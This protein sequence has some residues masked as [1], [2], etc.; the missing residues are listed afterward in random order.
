MTLDTALK[1][2]TSFGYHFTGKQHRN[3]IGFTYHFIY[4]NQPRELSAENLMRFAVALV[5]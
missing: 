4:N 2:V 1:T 3:G 5:A